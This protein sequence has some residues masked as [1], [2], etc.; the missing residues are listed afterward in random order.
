MIIVAADLMK[1]H[2]TWGSEGH[3]RVFGDTVHLLGEN[4]IEIKAPDYSPQRLLLN[5]KGKKPFAV[6]TPR[7]N[8]GVITGAMRTRRGKFNG[9]QDIQKT[10]MVP[11]YVLEVSYS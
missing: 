3:L 4:G 7:T 11:G 9:I 1:G 6:F 2:S 10:V 5:V 8:W